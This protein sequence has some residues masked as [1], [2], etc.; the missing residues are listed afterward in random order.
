MSCCGKNRLQARTSPERTPLRRARGG[1]VGPVR[2]MMLVEY[3][4]TGSITLR[5]PVTGRDYVLSRTGARISMDAR[6]HRELVRTV[7]NLR[8]VEHRG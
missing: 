7:T 3:R 8:L 5:G 6:D 4:G 1:P 2:Q